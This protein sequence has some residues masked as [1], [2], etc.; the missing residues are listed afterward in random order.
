VIESAMVKASQ[1]YVTNVME[2]ATD[3]DYAFSKMGGTAVSKQSSGGGMFG[4]SC[5]DKFMQGGRDLLFSPPKL[6]TLLS[7]AGG[8]FGSGGGAGGS[9][10]A[11][12]GGPGAMQQIAASMPSGLFQT[13]SGGFFPAF[14]S[15]ETESGV[16]SD[17]FANNLG[18]KNSSSAK[19]KSSG[20]SLF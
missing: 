12:S 15:G 9:S 19:L 5:L 13:G 7:M 17:T 4:G 20:S 1:N 11:C 10:V 18:I 3:G 2:T 6:S 8:M 14:A 16:G